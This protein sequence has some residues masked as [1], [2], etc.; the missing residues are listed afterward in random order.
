[1]R[2]KLELTHDQCDAITVASLKKAYRHN[3]VP[4]P[5]EGGADT[6]VDF[7]FLRAV[8]MVLGYFMNHDQMKE[9]EIEKCL[10]DDDRVVDR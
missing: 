5:D 4:L 2:Y 8:D 7:E 9:W 6:G 3:K 10:M 1:M